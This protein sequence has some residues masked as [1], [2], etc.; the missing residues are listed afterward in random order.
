MID[1]GFL[2][3]SSFWTRC[4][5]LKYH[6]CV[7]Y[8]VSFHEEESATFKSLSTRQDLSHLVKFFTEFFFVL[9]R[10]TVHKPF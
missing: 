5:L 3:K 1:G 8:N 10:A 4:C 7:A 9:N 2:E 6:W